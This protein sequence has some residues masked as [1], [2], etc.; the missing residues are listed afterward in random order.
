VR[1]TSSAYLT[2]VALGPGGERVPIRPVIPETG[3]ECRRYEGAQL[4]RQARLQLRQ[5]AM[6]QWPK[7]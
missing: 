4:R 6:T 7:K 3:E 5:K 1:H 2:F